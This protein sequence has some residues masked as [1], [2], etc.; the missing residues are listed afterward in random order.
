MKS[1]RTIL[2]CGVAT[3]AFNLPVIAPRAAEK[4]D[5]P[6]SIDVSGSNGPGLA[7]WSEHVDRGFY[8]NTVFK[9]RASDGRSSAF[10]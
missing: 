7:E 10:L 3:L 8:G 1:T 4:A 6:E 9:L 2:L 5:A